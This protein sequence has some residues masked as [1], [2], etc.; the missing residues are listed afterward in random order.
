M[1]KEWISVKRER[2]REEKERGHQR[3]DFRS[4]DLNTKDVSEHDKQATSSSPPP[5]IT[6]SILPIFQLSS[7]RCTMKMASCSRSLRRSS[8][9]LRKPRI[10][11]RQHRT[12]RSGLNTRNTLLLHIRINTTRLL[13][14]T[15]TH[16]ALNRRSRHRISS[17]P[18][19][20][21]DDAM[22]LLRIARRM[23]LKV[24]LGVQMQ[25]RGDLAARHIL[26]L[27]ME[28]DAI[29]TADAAVMQEQGQL[30]DRILVE[31]VV[32]FEFVEVSRGCDGVVAGLVT[33]QC[34][35]AVGFALEGAF[36]E[37]F[38]G[39]VALVGEA[40]VAHAS[41]GCVGV[42]EDVLVALDEAM[43]FK[44]QRDFLR[45]RGHVAVHGAVAFS[46][47]AHELG[48]GCQSALH[49]GKDVSFELL[50]AA[51]YGEEVVAVVVLV[52]YLL[53]ETMV[54]TSLKDVWIM[55]G[56]HFGTCRIKICRVLS[57]EFDVFLARITSL[58]HGF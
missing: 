36:D 6:N 16:V 45:G 48:E 3:E 23:R 57:E 46:L 52:Q 27:D 35:Q 47:A 20:S 11:Y 10:F 53:A 31:V 8:S 51:L 34:A 58:V 4:V 21:H 17:L 29:N 32:V 41:G 18:S 28:F 13:S 5:L 9:I 22:P 2:G 33:R 42:D 56:I 24:I 55:C 14:A 40:D 54:D 38:G 50:E 25:F 30:G 19:L 37:G 26:A 44:V 15:S 1:N 12:R 43:P 7:S 39:A 49:G